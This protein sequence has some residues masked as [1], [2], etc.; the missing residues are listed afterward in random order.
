[1]TVQIA[2]TITG[3][4]EKVGRDLMQ[5][6][7]QFLFYCDEEWEQVSAAELLL[8]ASFGET[9]LSILIESISSHFCGRLLRW[10]TV[11][12]MAA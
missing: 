11:L 2:G 8:P 6:E 9:F 4:D 5:Q 3:L 12:I 1:M 7:A 10:T